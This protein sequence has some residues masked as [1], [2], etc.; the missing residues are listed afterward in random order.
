ML[1]LLLKMPPTQSVYNIRIAMRLFMTFSIFILRGYP[2]NWT[3]YLVDTC[4]FLLSVPV[5]G[6]DDVS[7]RSAAMIATTT[8]F[9]QCTVMIVI[10]DFLSVVITSCTLTIF[11][12][13]LGFVRQGGDIL[14]IQINAN[15]E[16]VGVK[17]STF[18]RANVALFRSLLIIDVF[19]CLAGNLINF[20]KCGRVSVGGYC[21]TIHKSLV[22]L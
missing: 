16:V 2:S 6:Q 5:L 14:P 12:K 15:T 17:I 1:A 20:R 11:V 3:L 9:V 18:H 8:W 7:L 13:L 22:L 21:F 19:I 4:H 10:R